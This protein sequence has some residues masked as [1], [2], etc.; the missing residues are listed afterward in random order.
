MDHQ[1]AVRCQCRS[2]MALNQLEAPERV[3][4]PGIALVIPVPRQHVVQRGESL[5][6][7]ANRYGTTVHQLAR[8]NDIADPSLVYAVKC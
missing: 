3:L 4:V 5:W 7:I 2:N 1:P 6:L 8:A